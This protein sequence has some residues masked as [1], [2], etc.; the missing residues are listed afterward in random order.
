M[1]YITIKINND[2]KYENFINYLKVRNA[3]FDLLGKNQVHV[4]VKQVIFNENYF[5]IDSE[6]YSCLFDFAFVDELVYF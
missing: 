6:H 5:L 3:K 4:L 2:K 1:F